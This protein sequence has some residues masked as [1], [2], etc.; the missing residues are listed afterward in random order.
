[1][2]YTHFL[3]QSLKSPFSNFSKILSFFNRF[4]K[5]YNL[6]TNSSNQN[7]SIFIRKNQKNSN[8]LILPLINY[9]KIIPPY[10]YFLFSQKSLHFLS[11]FSTYYYSLSFLLFNPYFSPYFLPSFI[12]HNQKHFLLIFLYLIFLKIFLFLQN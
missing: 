9:K 6:I 3:R 8:N 7:L 11:F 4:R 10:L 1:M 12:S 5:L 2:S